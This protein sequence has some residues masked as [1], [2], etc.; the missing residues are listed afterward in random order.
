MSDD[1]RTLTG[2]I[3]SLWAEAQETQEADNADVREAAGGWRDRIDDMD[4]STLVW[5]LAMLV[6]NL[7]LLAVGAV[8][9]LNPHVGATIVGIVLVLVGLAGLADA[10]RNRLKDLRDWREGKQ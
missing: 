6:L 3:A 5:N 8:G 7:S 9:V 1:D 10:L 4:T 2:R